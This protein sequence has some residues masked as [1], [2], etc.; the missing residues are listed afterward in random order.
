M[1][2][3]LSSDADPKPPTSFSPLRLELCYPDSGTENRWSLKDWVRGK[4]VPDEMLRILKKWQRICIILKQLHNEQ[5]IESTRSQYAGCLGVRVLL[6]GA[7]IGLFAPGL[8]STAPVPEA[9]R[10]IPAPRAVTPIGVKRA[11]PVQVSL[12]GT[13]EKPRRRPFRGP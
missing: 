13:V 3:E 9:R 5:F 10:D 6:N 2:R 8:P 4:D 12:D 7:T 11:P 1:N